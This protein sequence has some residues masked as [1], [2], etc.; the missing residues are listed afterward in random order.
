VTGGVEAFSSFKEAYSKRSGL[1]I[2]FASS[3]WMLS[4]ASVAD[5][6]DFG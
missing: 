1:R 4:N 5:E 3:S 6:N 2:S